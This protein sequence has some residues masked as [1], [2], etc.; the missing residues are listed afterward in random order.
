MNR[1]EKAGVVEALG[2]RFSGAVGVLVADYRGLTVLEVND[3]RKVFRKVGADYAVV[4]NTLAKRALGGTALDEIKDW[5]KGTTAV[6]I[7]KTDA[8]AMAKAAI[9]FAKTHDKFKLRGAFVEGQ[10]FLNEGV[11]AL[12]NLP[13]KDEARASLLGV[14]NAPL[15]KLL[16]QFNAPAQH[17][18]GVLQAKVDKDNEG[19]PAEAAPAA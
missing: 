7:A 8:A 1:T 17:V 19:K 11:K 10:Q 6:A 14:I 9:D 12:A 18:V 3:L 2:K 15:A 13:T 4:K 16:A 5:F